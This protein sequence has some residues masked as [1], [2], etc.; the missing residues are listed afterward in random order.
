MERCMW[1][2]TAS[3]LAVGCAGI[4]GTP[5]RDAGG[6]DGGETGCEPPAFPAEM[7]GTWYDCV[8]SFTFRDDGSFHYSGLD[9]GCETQGTYSFDGLRVGLNVSTTTCPDSTTDRQS[10]FLLQDMAMLARE[11]TMIWV[12]PDLDIGHKY[13]IRGDGFTTQKWLLKG[14]DGNQWQELRMCLDEAGDLVVGYYFKP[15]GSDSLVSNS[16]RIEKLS[17][18]ADDP[19]RLQIRLSCQGECI[20]ASVINLTRSD[21]TLEGDYAAVNCD[22][23]SGTGSVTGAISEWTDYL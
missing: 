20:C 21:I 17:R 11:D 2:M 23:V 6:T 4:G 18:D 15:E 7:T 19:D 1:L 12:H 8:G 13:W 10:E 16:G 9:Q 5:S 14:E 3:L 22:G